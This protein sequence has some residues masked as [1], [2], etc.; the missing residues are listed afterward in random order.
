MAERDELFYRPDIPAPERLRE[1]IPD[2]L[3]EARAYRSSLSDL[4][5]I[6]VEDVPDPFSAFLD[7]FANYRDIALKIKE[8]AGFLL[9]K[10]IEDLDLYVGD[11]PLHVLRL[12]TDITDIHFTDPAGEP[13]PKTDPVYTLPVNVARCIFRVAGAYA[14]RAQEQP[15]LDATRNMNSEALKGAVTNKLQNASYLKQ[16]LYGLK[17]LGIVLKMAHVI[18]VH[19]T[20]GWTCGFFMGKL[21]LGWKFRV[22]SPV[23]KSFGFEWPAGTWVAGYLNKVES[24]LLA[25]VGYRCRK[26]STAPPGCDTEQWRKVDFKQV[27]CC[28]MEPIFFGPNMENSFA[29]LQSTCFDKWIRG[30]LDPEYA[31]VR[32]ICSYSNAD[33][34]SIE[35]TEFERV[36][37]QEVARYLESRPSIT[38][39]MGSSGEN[40]KPL[41][42]SIEAADAGIVMTE[43][44]S[45]AIKNNRKYRYT[46]VPSAPWDCFG[47]QDEDQRSP[48]ERLVSAVND[49]AG[50]FLPTNNGNPL[51]GNS[52]FKFLEQ[53]DNVLAEIIGFADRTVSIVANLAKWGSSK[54]LCC[55]IYL[56]VAIASVWRSLILKGHW[57]PDQT[58]GDAVRNELHVTWAREL[59]ANEDLQQFIK[60]LQVLK[61]IVD[62]FIRKMQRQI[63]LAGLTL[64]LGE[65][66]EMIKVTIANGLS[67]FLDILFGPL[68]QILAGLQSIPE[69]RHMINNECFGFD[70]FLKFL[71]CLLGNLKWGIINQIMSVLD[72]TLPDVVLLNDIMLSRMRLKSLEALSKL[73]GGIIDLLLNLRDCYDPEDLVNQIV[74]QEVR[75]E[76]TSV[77]NLV[78]LAGSPENLRRFDEY[79]EPLLAESNTFSPE[80]QAEIDNM[81]GSI[82]QQFGEFGSAAMEI[83]NNAINAPSLSVEA[84]VDPETG[85]IINMGQFVTLMEE[86][87]GT[88]V[89]EIQ[90]SMRY[91]FDILR[92]EGTTDESIG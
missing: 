46:G 32:T 69:I 33:N 20:V 58:D 34:D 17:L 85:E 83:V 29:F 92:G 53:I 2:A 42:R 27:N 48:E 36:A 28:V 50:R 67:E 12:I 19:Y 1:N 16:V 24:D 71:L 75:N 18:A 38:G 68:D 8:R 66:W 80:E 81:Q 70:K 82:A 23:G 15:Y 26:K 54:Q 14:P 78:N 73:L 37:A 72:F 61:Q 13:L 57:C 65:M 7:R 87:T 60:L 44:V 10:T 88:S 11:A 4:L 84:F 5:K 90:E 49:A 56:I 9:D 21:K 35:P 25:I 30:E 76:Y 91:I 74:Q 64:P 89:S 63:F 41:S 31:G 3:T 59:R 62:I 22:P 6:P 43:E 45:S 40:I 55:F 79:S 39:T 47:M 52:Y 77:Q 86:M 51:V